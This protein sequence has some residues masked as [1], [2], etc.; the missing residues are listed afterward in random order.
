MT[1]ARPMSARVAGLLGLV[2]QPNR[3][4]RLGRCRAYAPPTGGRCVRRGEWSSVWTSSD[5]WAYWYA[6]A[7]KLKMWGD[8]IILTSR[9][10][11]P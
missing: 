3:C 4:R 1:P 10:G 6:R 7:L 5:V 9:H 11:G 8:P 2:P